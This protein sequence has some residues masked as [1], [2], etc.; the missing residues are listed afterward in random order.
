MKTFLSLMVTLSSSPLSALIFWPFFRS[1]DST[2]GIESVE[3]DKGRYRY[4]EEAWLELMLL[5]YR[6]VAR[7]ADDQR[8]RYARVCTQHTYG[9]AYGVLA[10]LH[11]CRD[12]GFPPQESHRTHTQGSTHIHAERAKHAQ[13]WW[14]NINAG[15]GHS[16]T[17]TYRRP[18]QREAKLCSSVVPRPSGDWRVSVFEK[19][20][21]FVGLSCF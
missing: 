16:E 20:F 5:P 1:L 19:W 4:G 10:S 12:S 3:R 8:Q 14:V 11:T 18:P 13:M 2:A 6:C 7:A 21:T 17:D 9:K 15:A